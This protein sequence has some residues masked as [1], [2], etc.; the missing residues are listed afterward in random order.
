MKLSVNDLVLMKPPAKPLIQICCFPHRNGW[1]P[2]TRLICSSLLGHVTVKSLL[3]MKFPKHGRTL[4]PATWSSSMRI[5]QGLCSTMRV[6]AASSR[7]A[8]LTWATF[9][10][11]TSRAPCA[12]TP[13]LSTSLTILKVVPSSPVHPTSTCGRQHQPARTPAL[14]RKWRKK[15]LTDKKK[16][17]RLELNR[18]SNAAGSTCSTWSRSFCPCPRAPGSPSHRPSPR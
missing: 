1:V 9:I 16:K 17:T 4:W 15:G 14:V 12:S 8:S 18:R 3:L 11:S 5:T 10:V 2:S 7:P 13:A 6:S